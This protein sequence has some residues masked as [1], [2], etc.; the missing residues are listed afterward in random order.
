M[1]YF[2]KVT[3]NFQDERGNKTRRTFKKETLGADMAVEGALVKGQV[4]DLVAAFEA[5]TQASVTASIG[6]V[7]DS[8]G[9]DAPIAGSDVS[10]VALVN[11]YIA[12][13]PL[14]KLANISIPAPLNALFVGGSAGTDVDI[15]NAALIALVD[16]FSATWEISDGENVDVTVQ[17]GIKNGEWRGRYLN[18]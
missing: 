5:V 14:E 11:L 1:S 10:N 7:D 3:L 8:V 6:L 9:G 16:E 4:G 15:T 12:P 18:P 13:P 17:D 2:W